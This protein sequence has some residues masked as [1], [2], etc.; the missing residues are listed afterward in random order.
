[1]RHSQSTAVSAYTSLRPVARSAAGLLGGD[2]VDRAHEL[3]GFGH[4]R[5][6]VALGQPEVGEIGVV[7][8][9][10]EHVL[11]LDVAVDQP[12]R[13]RGVERL[14]HLR[15]QAQRPPVVELAP[16]DQILERG[17]LDHAH[18]EEQ[19]VVGLAGLIHGDDVGVVEGG[20]QQAL[21]AEALAE[22]GVGAEAPP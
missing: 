17:A 6:V 19:P 21:A 22:G 13:V 16:Q 5:V 10:D 18:R 11:R 7:A 15:E 20:L 3:A 9:A 8:G 4:R 1:M 2:V 14:G 12:L